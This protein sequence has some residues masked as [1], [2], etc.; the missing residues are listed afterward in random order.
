MPSGS[1]SRRSASR[2]R[3]R[4]RYRDQSRER[5]R[6]RIRDRDRS[7]DRSRE[8]SRERERSSE[9]IRLPHNAKPIAESDY[10]QK[11]DEFRIWLKDE[12]G[13]VRSIQVFLPKL[14]EADE[15]FCVVFRRI[16]RRKS[17]KVSRLFDLSSGCSYNIVIFARS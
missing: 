2:S 3:S 17:K 7:R 4:E 9:E 13:K 15:G 1:R 10:F 5:S 11:S 14:T 6:E 12:K 8:K 16:D